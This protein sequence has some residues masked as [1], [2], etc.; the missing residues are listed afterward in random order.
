MNLIKKSLTKSPLQAILEIKNSRF[1]VKENDIIYAPR[2]SSLLVGDVLEFNE[3]SEISNKDFIL[4]GSPYISKE[5]YSIKGVVI[6]H[7]KT[8]PMTKFVRG[9]KV[10]RKFI[11]GNFR[12]FTSVL[13]KEITLNEITLNEISINQKIEN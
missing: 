12:A 6:E 9:R 4:K 10:Q 3:I 5:Y 8:A 1:L 11:T 2:D 7:A 13:I